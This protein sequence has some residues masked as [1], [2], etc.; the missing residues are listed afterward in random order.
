MQKKRIEY[1]K[2]LDRG[3]GGWIRGDRVYSIIERRT[4]YWVN[5]RLWTIDCDTLCQNGQ[6]VH[7][8]I[9]V[10]EEK[11]NILKTNNED[12][13][14]EYLQ[15][16]RVLWVSS[17]LFQTILFALWKSFQAKKV[18]KV[19]PWSRNEQK[20]EKKYRRR[21]RVWRVWRRSSSRFNRIER[22]I[23]FTWISIQ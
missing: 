9:D 15:K 1:S 4:K 16:G 18:D 21:R 12:R 5:Q 19:D 14:G 17:S 13:R 11:K 7:Q 2:W 6:Y 10:E 3:L 8:S 22:N 20:E 23:F